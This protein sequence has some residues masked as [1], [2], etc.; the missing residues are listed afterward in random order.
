MASK[1]FSQDV[2]TPVIALV[3]FLATALVFAVALAVEILF[4]QAQA[5]QFVE[6]DLAARPAELT[7]LVDGQLAELN[8]YRWID[9][10]KK[11]VAIPIDRAMELVLR[12]QSTKAK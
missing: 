5:Q 2:N 10:E 6:K 3:G 9:Q 11:V 1:Q 4:Y 7:K 12:E 8:T